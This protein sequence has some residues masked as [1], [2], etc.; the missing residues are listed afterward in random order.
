MIIEHRVPVVE[1][2]L[3]T[4]NGAGHLSEFLESLSGQ[5][6][7]SIILRVSD[8]GSNDSTLDVINLY[9]TRFQEFS[10]TQGPGSGPSD[11]FF[12]LISRADSDFIALADQDDIWEPTHLINSV[13]RIENLDA[14]PAMTFT[15]VSE[16]EGKPENRLSIWPRKVKMGRPLNFFVENLARGCTIVFNRKALFLINSHKPAFAI[17][18][19]WWISL[20]ISLVG[21]V[22]YSQNPE[23]NYRIHAG[24]F[25]GGRPRLKLRLQR[26]NGSRAIDWPPITQLREIYAIYG[27]RISSRK[28]RH[29]DQ[30]VSGLISPNFL[31]RAR[32]NL[33]SHRFR[34]SIVDDSWLR[35]LL[36]TR[37]YS[38]EPLS[39]FIYRRLRALVRKV[40]LVITQEFPEIISDFMNIKILK[41]HLRQV[42][43]KESVSL[44]GSKKIAVVALYPR[45]SLLSS[46]KR[47]ISS[48]L[49]QNY[50]VIAVVNHPNLKDWISELSGFPITIIQRQNVGRDFGAYKCGVEYIERFKLGDQL[51]SLLLCNDSVIYGQ[52]FGSFL[53]EF[54]SKSSHWATAFL[55]FEKHTHAQSFF[56]S[57]PR[58]IL[59]TELFKDFWR[60]YYPSNRRIYAID[61]GEVRLSQILL[62][63]G[64]FPTSVV[65]AKIISENY[66]SEKIIVE[67]YFSIL[68]EK[69]YQFL[70]LT[71]QLKLELF[72]HSL[73]RGF[74]EKN[75]SHLVGLLA[76]K[77]IGAPLKIDLVA[78]GKVS[79]DSLQKALLADGLDV[80]EVEGLVQEFLSTRARLA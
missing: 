41:S 22:R 15:S 19:D 58:E 26:F 7:V 67:D 66:S 68:G 52:R 10:I 53:R 8:D 71:N 75:C 46:V 39:W 4:Y 37:P 77:A 62:S 33:T 69:Y 21:E 48:L 23:V 61:Q 35:I 16:F 25:V 50:E 76:F 51:D 32:A 47:L 12:S 24:N 29:V 45:G 72:W 42:V 28:L 17:M 30:I 43:I 31:K 59:L 49:D 18:H 3:A 54:E 78:T 74:M 14:V 65:N 38:T 9:S 27:S 11:N 6:G 57:F 36:M 44:R 64:F 40:V 63:H 13:K 5:Q 1:V 80:I 56:Q 55:N 73:G 70:G 79:I 2:L 34:T 20:L 60:N